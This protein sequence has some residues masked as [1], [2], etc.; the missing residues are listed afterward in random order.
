LVAAGDR[1]SFEL[2]YLNFSL[3]HVLTA[4]LA[5]L[6][7]GMLRGSGA[8]GDRS[9]MDDFGNVGFDKFVFAFLA[10]VVFNVANLA[11]CKGI[12]MLGL[13]L[14]FPLCVGTGMVLGTVLTYVIQPSGNA[15]LLFFGVALAFCAVCAAALMHR[16][17]EQQQRQVGEESSQGA[18]DVSLVGAVHKPSMTRKLVVCIVGG[19]LMS[20][21]NPLVALAEKDPGLSSYT[22]FAVFT[23]AALLSSLVLIPIV[24]R[25]P[26]EGGAGNAVATVLAQ[27]PK[28][29]AICHMY[30]L[31][32]GVVWA[33]GTLMNFLAGSSKALTSAESYAI[34]QCANMAAIFWGVFLFK[35]FEG[36]DAR[37]KGLI[38]LV[39]VLYG[40]AIALVTAA[41]S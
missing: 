6:T 39:I 19:M 4:W 14:A 32:S 11:L 8:G 34:G 1:I 17:K 35:E 27:Y 25:F 23:F 12:S 9:S 28:T 15:T 29:P 2:F 22:C 10:G 18:R 16:L 31:L 3:G 37:V 33:V 36:T 41:G 5:A 38:A 13:A 30:G 40:C 20:I 24:I 26:L 7:F 21:F